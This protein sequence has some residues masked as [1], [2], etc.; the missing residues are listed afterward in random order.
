MEIKIVTSL[1]GMEDLRP[2][3]DGL[4]HSSSTRT[5][6]QTSDWI[7][8]WTKEFMEGKLEIITVREGGKLLGI[9]PLFVERGVTRFLGTPLSDYN[10]F[11]IHKD[12]TQDVLPEI[13]KAIGGRRMHLQEIP[14]GSCI[15]SYCQEN[16]IGLISHIADTFQFMIGPDATQDFEKME[17]AVFKQR[18]KLKMFM[19][20]PDFRFSKAIDERGFEDA[21]SSLARFH[22]QRWENTASPSYFADP[23]HK[24][25]FHELYLSLW[26]KGMMQLFTVF[27]K[28]RIIAS[29]VIYIYDRT[30]YS[31]TITYDKEFSRVSPGNAN[32]LSIIRHAI[33]EGITCFD[34]TRGDQSYKSEYSN[35]SSA[36][37]ELEVF[38]GLAKHIHHIRKRAIQKLRGNRPLYNR[39]ME[40]REKI[41]ARLRH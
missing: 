18:R 37:Y 24:R 28:D 1:A 3:W 4:M 32:T 35:H 38:T 19:R 27:E 11:I 33:D 14:G 20:S 6:F 15:L 17:H 25:F 40:T 29:E 34:F 16:G 36:N 26:K 41:K 2:E 39:I 31:Y 10:D 13:F 5:F 21:F 30:Y 7:L 22:I 9:A 8:A 23:K 12:H